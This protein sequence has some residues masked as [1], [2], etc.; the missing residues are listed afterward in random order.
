MK[1]SNE[2]KIGVMVTAVLI[3]LF[4]LTVKSGDFNFKKEGYT[5]KVRFSNIDGIG[6]SS[7]VML[8]GLEVGLVKKIEIYEGKDEIKLELTVFLEEHVKL[9]EGSQAYVKNMGF[10]GEK[11]VGLTPGNRHG[12]ILSENAVIIGDDPADLD[13]LLLDGKEIAKQMKEL[14]TNL[15][16]RVKKNSEKIDNIFTNTDISMQ[17]FKS[18]TTNVNERLVVNKEKIDDTFTHLRASSINLDEFTYDLK[19]NPWKLMYRPKDKK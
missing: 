12:K 1:W 10:M 3:I 16:E 4:M 19:N 14:T 18:I 9:R 7:P 11:Y 5:V 8:N 13:K 2:T 15:N 6:L 17:K